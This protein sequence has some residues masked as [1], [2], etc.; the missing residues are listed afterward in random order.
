MLIYIFCSII[1]KF[2]PILSVFILLGGLTA[3]F[4][5]ETFRHR[6]FGNQPRG[7]PVHMDKA[8]DKCCI[9]DQMEYT[10]NTIQSFYSNDTGG[11]LQ[12]VSHIVGENQRN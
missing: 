11:F 1:M 8:P 7:Q 9:P 12:V 5:D 10:L 6:I 2:A 4:S 3:T